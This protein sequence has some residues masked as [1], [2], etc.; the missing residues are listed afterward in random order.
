MPLAG[1]RVIKHEDRRFEWVVG[2]RGAHFRIVIQDFVAGGQLLVAWHPVF[3]LCEVNE[4]RGDYYKRPRVGVGLLGELIA[5][6]LRG[7]AA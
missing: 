1:G 4:A 5:G 7:L 3:W 6:G 2:R